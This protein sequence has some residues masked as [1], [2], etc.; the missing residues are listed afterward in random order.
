MLGHI[1]SHP[2]LPAI[3]RPQ[4][5]QACIRLQSIGKSLC[6]FKVNFLNQWRMNRVWAALE[7]EGSERRFQAQIRAPSCFGVPGTCLGHIWYKPCSK[8]GQLY[9]FCGWRPRVLRDAAQMVELG[10]TPSW[11]R[12]MTYKDCVLA[13]GRARGRTGGSVNTLLLWFPSI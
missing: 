10:F 9:P 8:R 12:I 3:H 7:V 6:F 2:G 13:S 5:R 4:V 1:K 11:H